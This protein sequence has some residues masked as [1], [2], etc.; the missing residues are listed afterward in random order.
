MLSGWRGLE[1][2]K[3]PVC[4]EG[5]DPDI[6][7]PLRKS[8]PDESSRHH[9]RDNT[10]ACKVCAPDEEELTF[11][12]PSLGA[13]YSLSSSH[14]WWVRSSP[15]R[16]RHS[17]GLPR[18]H[19][20]EGPSPHWLSPAWLRTRSCS[21]MAALVR[22]NHS[23]LGPTDHQQ[24]F[25]DGCRRETRAGTSRGPARSPA[26]AR[27]SPELCLSSDTSLCPTWPPRA[28]TRWDLAAASGGESPCPPALLAH[29][30]WFCPHGGPQASTR[31]PCP[32]RA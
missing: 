32:R 22:G 12:A 16:L 13:H 29:L 14:A 5:C 10:S 25:R 15:P 24:R 4:G 27:A 2:P 7:V 17:R 26:R 9:H 21:A 31:G 11:R 30:A 3:G 23:L 20:V 8:G 28:E 19:G 18:A 1:G 6:S